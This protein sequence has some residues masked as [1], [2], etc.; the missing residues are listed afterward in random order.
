VGGVGRSARD[1]YGVIPA[2]D[3]GPAVAR[4]G[5]GRV[6]GRDGAHAHVSRRALGPRVGPRAEAVA[7]N[8]DRARDPRAPHAARFFSVV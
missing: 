4:G 6:R 3:A 7:E 2:V 1:G 8:A 5:R